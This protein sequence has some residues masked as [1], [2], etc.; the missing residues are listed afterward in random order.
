MEIDEKE[1]ARKLIALRG[2]RTQNEVANALKIS[3]SALS[4]YESGKRIPRDSVKM[5]ISNYYKKSIPYIF[6]NQKEH[7]T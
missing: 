7:E 6:F 5:R 3:K 1:M 4:M 2:N